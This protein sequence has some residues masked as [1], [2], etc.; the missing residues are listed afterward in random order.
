MTPR[1]AY[2]LLAVGFLCVAINIHINGFGILLPTSLG[3]FLIALG[4]YELSY[5]HR[6]FSFASLTA[7]PLAVLTLPLLIRGTLPDQIRIVYNQFTFWPEMVLK[8]TVFTFIAWGIWK[9]ASLQNH[10]RMKQLSLI[11]APVTVCSLL[12]WW[13]V[14]E[15]DYATKLISF[16]AY[17]VPMFY[18]ALLSR[19]AVSRLT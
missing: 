10:Q 3:Y 7:V 14:P 19:L 16:M 15:I 5:Q 2:N 17:E 9:T 4:A 6:I 13:F 18:L 12:A 1:E 11:V 8:L